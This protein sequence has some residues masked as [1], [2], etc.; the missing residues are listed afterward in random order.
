MAASDALLARIAGLAG[1]AERATTALELADARRELDRLREPERLSTAAGQ[2]LATIQAERRAAQRAAR[3]QA[4][5]Q[6]PNLAAAEAA[7]AAHPRNS[8]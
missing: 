5:R 1:V 7:A 6:M 8:R 2:A 3:A 4:L